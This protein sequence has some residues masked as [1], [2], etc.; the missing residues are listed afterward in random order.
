MAAPNAAQDKRVL[1]IQS[2]V[3]AGYVGMPWLAEAGLQ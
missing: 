1:S 3:V 2:H